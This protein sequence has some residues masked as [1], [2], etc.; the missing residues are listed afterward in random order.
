[1][2][3]NPDTNFSS[4]QMQYINPSIEVQ[5]KDSHV[6][7]K[8]NDDSLPEIEIDNSFDKDKLSAK[9]RKFVSDCEKNIHFFFCLFF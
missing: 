3:S 7:V 5:I 2:Y 9:E 4:I 8:V 6:V 1:M